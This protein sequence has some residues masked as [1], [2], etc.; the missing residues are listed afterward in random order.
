MSTTTT[1]H[2]TTATAAT[3]AQQAHSAD[4]PQTDAAQVRAN[5]AGHGFHLQLP[6]QPLAAV[7]IAR[8]DGHDD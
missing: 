3:S 2:T 1:P 5:L 7:K 6:P 4:A 8:I